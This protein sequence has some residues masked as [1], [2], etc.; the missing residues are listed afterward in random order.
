MSITFQK[1]TDPPQK[2]EHSVGSL[3]LGAFFSGISDEMNIVM[4]AC[5][6]ASEL[7]TYNYQKQQNKETFQLG[8]KNS[9]G[10]A[11]AQSI[12][13]ANNNRAPEPTGAELNGYQNQYTPEYH[14]RRTMTMEMAA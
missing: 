8:K 4:D 14:S 7:H 13:S 9:L 5:E 3:L 11:F 2:Q 6:I 12:S 10:S 1:Q